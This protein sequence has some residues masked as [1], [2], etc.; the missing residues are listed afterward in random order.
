MQSL[1]QGLEGQRTPPLGLG[2]CSTGATRAP[3][4]G[5]HDAGKTTFCAGVGL[6]VAGVD[7]GVGEGNTDAEG[8]EGGVEGVG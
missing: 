5:V 7:V 6:L 4:V 3:G 8:N 2:A 1:V